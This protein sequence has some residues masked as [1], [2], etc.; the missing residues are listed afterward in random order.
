MPPIPGRLERCGEQP[1]TYVD[2]AH[3]AR[4][5]ELVIAAVRS[6]HRDANIVCVFGCG[7]DRDNGK[8]GPMGCAAVTAD[9]AVLTTDNPR[10]E[11]PESIADEVLRG[12][13]LLDKNRV[14]IE[15]DR[16]SAIALAR[17][18][19]GVDGVVVVCGKGHERVQIIGS[20]RI[21]SDDRELVRDCSQAEARG[22]T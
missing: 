3:T 1:I 13:P 11:S 4:S 10:S 12:I 15:H 8:R 17:Y 14:F 20:Q 5:L 16:R 6:A 19:A 9:W 2:Y 7:G 22:D 21:L 18:K